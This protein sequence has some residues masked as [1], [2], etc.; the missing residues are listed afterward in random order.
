MVILTLILIAFLSPQEINKKHWKNIL[1][2]KVLLMSFYIVEIA[3]IRTTKNIN[4]VDVRSII[5]H[6]INYR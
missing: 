1:I 5:V 2:N 6:I 4:V 3:G